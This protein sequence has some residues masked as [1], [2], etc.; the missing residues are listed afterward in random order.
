MDVKKWI[1]FGIHPL[2]STIDA[3]HQSNLLHSFGH[4][5]RDR[6]QMS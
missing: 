1:D 5:L 3:C 2:A 4:P 6:F